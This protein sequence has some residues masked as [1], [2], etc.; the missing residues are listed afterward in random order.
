MVEAGESEFSWRLKTHKLLILLGDKMG[1]N[2][3]FA[4][5][6]YTAGTQG[7]NSVIMFWSKD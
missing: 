1:K 6:R 2:R 4:Q 5:V 7:R 3:E